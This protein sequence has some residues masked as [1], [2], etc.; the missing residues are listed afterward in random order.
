MLVPGK[1][2]KRSQIFESKARLGYGFAHKC[3]KRLN[4]LA[5]GKRSSLFVESAGDEEKSFIRLDT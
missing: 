4:R 3:E 5:G 2:F 1:T